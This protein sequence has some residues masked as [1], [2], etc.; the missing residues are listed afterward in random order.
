MADD[1]A[2]HMEAYLLGRPVADLAYVVQ[3]EGC[4]LLG[5]ED[6]VAGISFPPFVKIV[7]NRLSG[8]AADRHHPALV[9][10]PLDPHHP[11]PRGGSFARNRPADPSE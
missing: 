2:A 9:A 10:L 8:L 1:V 11:G 6:V 4:L 3:G 7:V 5:A